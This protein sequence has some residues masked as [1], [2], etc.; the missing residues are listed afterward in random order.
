M[1]LFLECRIVAACVALWRPY[2][3]N[4]KRQLKFRA[5]LRTLP[6][7]S[8]IQSRQETNLSK[9]TNA[10]PSISISE[11]TSILGLWTKA[12]GSPSGWRISGQE[13]QETVLLQAGCRFHPNGTEGHVG[14]AATLETTCSLDSTVQLVLLRHETKQTVIRLEACVRQVSA[15]VRRQSGSGYGC[16]PDMSAA[17]PIAV[18]GQISVSARVRPH[19]TLALCKG[20]PV[21]RVRCSS[22]TSIPFRAQPGTCPPGFVPIRFSWL[23]C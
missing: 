7:F 19:K 3:R 20:P 17:T 14:S 10:T 2:R 5:G 18:Y 1:L 21:R 4:W 8:E 16:P 12:P 23:T 22:S 13:S 9:S 15:C 11:S 6:Q